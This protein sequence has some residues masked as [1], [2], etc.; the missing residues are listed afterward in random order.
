M[1]ECLLCGSVFKQKTDT[2]NH[3]KT[4]KHLKHF[5]DEQIVLVKGILVY[6]YNDETK[7]CL[8]NSAGGT[9]KTFVVSNTL[10]FVKNVIALGPTHQSVNV[11]KEH[12]KVSK[13][14]HSFFGWEQDIDEFGNDISVWK[15]PYIQK[16][17]IFVFDEISMMNDAMFSLYNHYIKGK[18]KVI[19]M[20]D[21]AQLPPINNSETE[22]LPID[23]KLITSATRFSSF[24]N[25]SCIIF[26]LKKNMRCKKENL[27]KFL[28]TLREATLNNEEYDLEDNKVLNE[29][30]LI[31][32]KNTDYIVLCGANKDVDYFNKKIKQILFPDNFE[33]EIL[34]G[35]KCIVNTYY[36]K[37]L[38]TGYRFQIASFIKEEIKLEPFN[39][40][41][42]IKL[43]VPKQNNTSCVI[44]IFKIITSCNNTLIKV[45]D[46]D[47]N[48]YKRL[49]KADKKYIVS[50][51]KEDF[52]RSINN[53]ELKNIKCELQK[54]VKDKFSFHCYFKLNF[55]TTVH[56]AQG[57]GFENVIVYNKFYHQ[58]SSNNKYT[59]CSRTKKNIYISSKKF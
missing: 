55:A 25:E 16:G 50:L 53:I 20:G 15:K 28:N 45:C 19:F 3:F 13:T 1:Y 52:K 32:I 2:L 44:S 37:K 7:P 57:R 33:D 26:N 49:Y 5:N 51:K 40:T 34:V 54:E 47:F 17:T 29:D 36:T 23:V 18:Y 10:S 4:K 59:A 56:K 39:F 30:F 24:F 22:K 21:K 46:E 6:L 27:N 12:F 42:K 58:Q 14:F 8:V 43:K 48:S 9:G 38:Y 11:L 41:D 35:D 31:K